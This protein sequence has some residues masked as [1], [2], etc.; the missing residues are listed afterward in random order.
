MT[1]S[2]IR[3]RGRWADMSA[4]DRADLTTR[5]IGRVFD[6]ELRASVLE[7][8][9]DVRDNGDAGLLRALAKF[10]K[11]EVDAEG[12][13][14]SREEFAAARAEIG[15][16]MLS[17]IRES[18]AFVR[19]YNERMIAEDADWSFE[20]APGVVVGERTSPIES[21][22]LFVPAGK[23][24]FPSVLVQLGTPAVVA[25]VPRIAVV[26][27]P[28]P[29]SGGKVDPA[30]LVVAD[31][32]GITDV[33]RVNGPAGIGA[34]AFGT[35]TVPA[36]RKVV[37]PGSP[38]VAVA[39]IEVQRFGVVSNMLLGPSE[40]LILADDSADP[41][42]LAADLLNEAE[43]GPDS[44]S[45][46]VTTSSKLL[47]A[48]QVEL[49]DQLAQ[50]PAPRDEYARLALHNGGAVLVD[51]ME[52]GAEV[53][54]AYAP[55]HMQLV[56]RD[57]EYVLGLIVDAAEILVGQYTTVSMANFALG[58]PAALPTSGYAK[59]SS[60]I[61]AHTF[62]KKR[63]V[64]KA[65]PEGLRALAPTVLAFTAHEGFPAHGNSVAIRL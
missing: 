48:V 18:I 19:R 13:R 22:G 37:G 54:N 12:I 40:S 41:R 25:G 57:E 3:D 38:P 2:S 43:H 5:G 9:E 7:I 17:A 23:G 15:E 28:V 24:S 45:V 32:L 14:V 31:E 20:T 47:A 55:E 42:L 29:G 16:E 21:V 4:A 52:E 44:S 64:A 1:T 50:L 56:A 65:S 34:L 39:Q 63:A 46:L 10:D 30:I 36:V 11:V 53:A 8:L 60:G 58:C 33:F 35:E 62:R 27:P 6:P 61:T 49:A 51:S 26:T 59:V